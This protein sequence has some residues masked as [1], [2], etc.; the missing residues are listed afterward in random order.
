MYQNIEYMK[1]II[2]RISMLEFFLKVS[3]DKK[4]ISFKKYE[5][6]GIYLLDTVKMVNSW[7]KNEKSK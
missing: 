7:I 3:L 4:L 2:V 5:I 1:E 6:V